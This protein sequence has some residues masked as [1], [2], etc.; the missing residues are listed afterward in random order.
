MCTDARRHVSRV[1][2]Q[3]AIGIDPHEAQEHIMSSSKRSTKKHAK[4][5]KRRRLKGPYRT[6]AVTGPHVEAV[7]ALGVSLFTFGTGSL[8]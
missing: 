3:T 4:A 8:P 6:V 5:S 2:G 7:R 1:L